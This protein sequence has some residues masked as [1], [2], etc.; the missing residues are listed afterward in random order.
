LP[1]IIKIN[2]AGQ[3]TVVKELREIMW[4]ALHEEATFL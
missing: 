1:H 2:N 4:A 3:I